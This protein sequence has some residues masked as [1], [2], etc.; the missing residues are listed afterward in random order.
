M[1]QINQLAEVALSQFFWL[2]LTLGIIY[3][4]IAKAMVPKIQQTVEARDKRIAD[5]LAAAERARA[6]ADATEEEYR[7]KINA[8]RD[9]VHALILDAKSSAARATE[10]RLGEVDAGIEAKAADATA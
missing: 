10:A 4:G 8:A 5:D 6:E 1:P 7:G 9:E 2:L 3:F